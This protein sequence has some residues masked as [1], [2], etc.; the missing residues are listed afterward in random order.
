[1]DRRRSSR[2]CCSS[3]VAAAAL[4][5]IFG[6]ALGACGSGTGKAGAAS[7]RAL[8]DGP[9][10]QCSSS[11]LRLRTGGYG[12]SAGAFAQTFTFTNISTAS[13]W[14]GGWPSFQVESQSVRSET[15]TEKVRQTVS[16]APAFDRVV[17]RPGG[18]ASFRV[19]NADYDAANARSC[20]KTSQ[21][22]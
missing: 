20:P 13:C 22:W 15:A 21:C 2:S 6:G 19:F 14:L 7:E 1:M 8:S 17:L 5:V 16:P 3:R 12:E 11:Q 10:A 9:D 4:V 18:E